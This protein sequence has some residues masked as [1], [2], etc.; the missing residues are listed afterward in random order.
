M[1]SGRFGLKSL[2]YSLCFDW[3][4]SRVSPPLFFPGRRPFFSLR[5][6]P[7]RSL[8]RR[9]IRCGGQTAELFFLLP[10]RFV[11]SWSS[12]VHSLAA[13]FWRPH[14]GLSLCE[15]P[16]RAREGWTRGLS[17]PFESRT[18]STKVT[19]FPATG[20]FFELPPVAGYGTIRPYCPPT[21]PLI[22]F[23]FFLSSSTVGQ[24]R[25]DEVPFCGPSDDHGYFRVVSGSRV[26]AL[27]SLVLYSGGPPLVTEEVI[28][29]LGP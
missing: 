17:R 6:V 21:F 12:S 13:R 3:C 23:S 22:G 2:G 26:W 14:T 11:S 18:F 15:P 24:R 20:V 9:P 19:S 29:P 5:L 10:G 7:S 1:R 8:R 28:R 27:P 16:W 25:M 4:R